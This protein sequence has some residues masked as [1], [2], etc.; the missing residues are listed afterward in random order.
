[1]AR[2]QIEA[3][4]LKGFRDLLP[5]EAQLRISLFNHIRQIFEDS[6]YLP[7]DTPTLEYTEIL[8][9]KG[10]DETDKQLFRFTDQ[11]ERDVAMRF[12]LTVPFARFTAQHRNEL[13]FPFRRYHI[14]PVWRAEKPQ[15]GRYRE[16]YQCD[17]DIIGTKDIGSDIETL[18]TASRVFDTIGLP[19]VI[20]I[21]H[22]EILNAV[23][24]SFAP[25][26]KAT[27]VLRAID[28]LE[29]LGKETVQRELIDEAALSIDTAHALINFLLELRTCA[30]D[31]TFNLIEKQIK[32]NESA[33]QAL[34]RM[35][36][37]F[38]ILQT[39]SGDKKRFSFDI[40][41]AR[42]LDYYTGIVFETQLLEFP[43]LGSVCSGGRYDNLASLFT[44]QE[45]PGVGGSVGI[46]RLLVALNE[47]KT[48]LSKNKDFKI[49]VTVFS[50]ELLEESFAV[51][52]TLRAA[53][54]S[55]EIYPNISK[56]GNQLKYADKSG[57]THAL[58]IGPEEKE[59][60]IIQIKTLSETESNKKNIEKSTLLDFFQKT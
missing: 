13:Q 41:I 22:R 1:M 54:I 52:E 58:I 20:R 9:G 10:S 19:Y 27:S 32:A 14:A 46:D 21:N 24:S 39:T 42:G 11:G 59:K 16:F 23:I 2:P 60:N 31:Q 4:I 51:A 25:N 8:L 50:E 26:A 47:Q 57:F 37:T 15:R 56:M 53:H 5:Q 28:K 38:S 36:K 6:C 44:S 3:K 29:K 17:F 40:T 55:T 7:I 34:D 48:N 33:F 18:R 43:D 45:L 49:L 35:K 12:D 30:Q